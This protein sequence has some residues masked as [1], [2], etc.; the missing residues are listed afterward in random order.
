MKFKSSAKELKI[1][2]DY[3]S[4]VSKA[5]ITTNLVNNIHDQK[6]KQTVRYIMT[7][8]W[9]IVPKRS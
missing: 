5:L 1:I 3:F 4:V 6:Q 2:C 9:R 7:D 8:S